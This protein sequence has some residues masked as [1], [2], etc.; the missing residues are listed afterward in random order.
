METDLFQANLR[1]I[2]NILIYLEKLS[3][4]FVDA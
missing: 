2:L 3:I 1:R 4:Q